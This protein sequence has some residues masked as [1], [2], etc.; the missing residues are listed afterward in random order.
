MHMYICVYVCICFYVGEE[1]G[2]DNRQLCDDGSGQTLTERDIK[3]MK[4]E[5]IA[6]Q[7]H[8]CFIYSEQS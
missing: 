2:S 7:V 6:G 8:V 5:G 1:C 4:G 3:T